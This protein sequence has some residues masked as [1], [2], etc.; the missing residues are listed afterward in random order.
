[1]RLLLVALTTTII[2]STGCAAPPP[3]TAK[4]TATGV[5]T[6]SYRT[7]AWVAM[8][9]LKSSG[10]SL[11]AA[12]QLAT[13]AEGQCVA[14]RKAVREAVIAENASEPAGR[15]AFAESYTNKLRD[16]IIQGLAA[17]FGG[18]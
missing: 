11:A 5:A 4:S 18:K 1:M 17:D 6:E 10:K 16:T 14:Q 7:C 3:L 15:D 12:Q 2:S 9:S 8:G 13:A